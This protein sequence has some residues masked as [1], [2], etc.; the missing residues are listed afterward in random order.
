MMR[1]RSTT[2]HLC[3]IRLQSYTYSWPDGTKFSLPCTL[4]P[5]YRSMLRAMLSAA[6]VGAEALDPYSSLRC[7]VEAPIAVGSKQF[8]SQTS[9]VQGSDVV[10]SNSNADEGRSTSQ[11]HT[12]AGTALASAAPKRAGAD[13]NKWSQRQQQDQQQQQHH[14]VQEFQQHAPTAAQ[15]LEAML[16]WNRDPYLRVWV[17][18]CSCWPFIAIRANILLPPVQLTITFFAVWARVARLDCNSMEHECTSAKATVSI[19]CHIVVAFRVC[20]L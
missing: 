19:V 15:H 20:V 13:V 18:C 14:F 4:M 12:S 9:G 8:A 1:V 11:Q 3:L 2:R 7:P 6:K 5:H 17:C 10:S 16:P